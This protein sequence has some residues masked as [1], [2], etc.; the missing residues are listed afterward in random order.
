MPDTKL[1]IFVRL[2]KLCGGILRS[3]LFLSA[4]EEA[5]QSLCGGENQHDAAD[6]DNANEQIAVF[7]AHDDLRANRTGE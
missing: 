2:R 1:G 5:K 6:D 4:E 3:A 7:F